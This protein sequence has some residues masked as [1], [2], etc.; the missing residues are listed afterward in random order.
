MTKPLLLGVL[1]LLLGSALLSQPAR[2]ARPGKGAGKKA[3]FAAGGAKNQQKVK[4][5]LLIVELTQDNF[6][7]YN[8][9]LKL[10]TNAPDT[11]YCVPPDAPQKPKGYTIYKPYALTT[12]EP[13]VMSSSTMAHELPFKVDLEKLA[14]ESAKVVTFKKL[15]TVKSGNSMFDSSLHVTVLKPTLVKAQ[16]QVGGEGWVASLQLLTAS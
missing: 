1:L 5:A 8:D 6:K 11:I 9:H 13:V 10:D 16:D 15:M 4:N 14:Y 12:K 2:G 7:E 3:G